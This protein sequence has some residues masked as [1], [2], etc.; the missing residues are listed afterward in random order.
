[1]R[2]LLDEMLSAAIA[3][4]LRDRGHDAIAVDESLSLRG[5]PDGDLFAHAQREQRALAT[6]NRDDF[7]VLDREYRDRGSNH[8]GIVILN[9][10][11]FSQGKSTIGKLVVALAAFVASGPPYPS[12]VHWL[13]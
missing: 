4:Q 11:R 2:L 6:Y 7:L 9:P 13:Q 3:E 1:V 8:H 5:L 10:R 12:F